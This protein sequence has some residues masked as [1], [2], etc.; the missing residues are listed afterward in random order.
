MRFIIDPQISY[1]LD[2]MAC[3]VFYNSNEFSENIEDG[4]IIETIFLDDYWDLLLNGCKNLSLN[5]HR[6]SL[7]SKGY[8]F[9]MLYHDAIL[10]YP[11]CA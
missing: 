10:S 9:K 11:L 4:N 6:L 5:H 2:Y 8:T 3:F 7:M 1:L